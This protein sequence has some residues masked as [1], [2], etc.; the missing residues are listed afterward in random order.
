ME[1]VLACARVLGAIAFVTIGG[2][3]AQ[4][5]GGGSGV[6][7]I[8][9][10]DHAASSALSVASL[11][12]GQLFGS[13]Q[14][15]GTNPSGLDCAQPC[16][17]GMCTHSIGFGCCAPGVPVDPLSALLPIAGA[18]GGFDSADSAVAGTNPEVPQEPPQNTA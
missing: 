8:S 16:S 10:V 9:D 6:A 2:Q 3:S 11:G 4:V 7:T 14:L 15:H 1:W 13:G 12:S 17:S 5:D 18:G